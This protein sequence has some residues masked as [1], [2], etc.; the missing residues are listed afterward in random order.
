MHASL[1]KLDSIIQNLA[2]SD[3]VHDEQ[4]AGCLREIRQLLEVILTR[5]DRGGARQ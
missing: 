2:Y 3:D 5:L 4:V 1:Q